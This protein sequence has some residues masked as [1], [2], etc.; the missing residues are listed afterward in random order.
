[1]RRLSGCNYFITVGVWGRRLNHRRYIAMI[2][3]RVLRY[4]AISQIY[5]LF[6]DQSARLG[7]SV[8][9]QSTYRC[10]FA[11]GFARSRVIQ[12]GRAYKARTRVN[13]SSARVHFCNR[14][15][16]QPVSVNNA[17]IGRSR[18]ANRISVE[19]QCRL[20]LHTLLVNT[21]YWRVSVRTGK[22]NRVNGRTRLSS[23][24]KWIRRRWYI[25]IIIKYRKKEIER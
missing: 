21:M 18:D 17:F 6:S 2:L 22:N 24:L 14:E 9:P 12:A 3:S 11:W 19:T 20:Q 8:K 7:A 1:M 4:R 23:L 25:E 5:K 16:M 13:W 10:N 15:D